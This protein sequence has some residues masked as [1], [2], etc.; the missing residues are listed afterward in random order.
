MGS[1]AFTQMSVCVQVSLTSPGM[2]VNESNGAGRLV[3][4]VAGAAAPTKRSTSGSTQLVKFPSDRT[5]LLVTRNVLPK[6]STGKSCSSRC[7]LQQPFELGSGGI[8][9][10]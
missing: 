2:S 7:W 4:T 8:G 6:D 5:G 10:S 1:L 3:V 9:P